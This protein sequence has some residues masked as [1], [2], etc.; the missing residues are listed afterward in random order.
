MIRITVLFVL[1]QSLESDRTKDLLLYYV[2]MWNVKVLHS[3]IPPESMSSDFYG[4]F[5]IHE[6]YQTANASNV[7]S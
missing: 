2:I 1:N 3:L 7:Q 4:D 6:H 5:S